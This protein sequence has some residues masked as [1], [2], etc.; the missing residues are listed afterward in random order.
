MSR[1][2]KYNGPAYL[3]IVRIENIPQKMF[4]KPYKQ[5]HLSKED[6]EFID[7]LEKKKSSIQGRYVARAAYLKK[8][9]HNR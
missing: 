9:V 8:L 3:C 7:M 4:S 5:W 1:F 6:E 2:Q